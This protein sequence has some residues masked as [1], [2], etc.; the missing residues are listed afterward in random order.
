MEDTMA[1]DDHGYEVIQRAKLLRDGQAIPRLGLGVWQVP[2]GDDCVRSV[3]WA[4]EL[5]YRHID[6]AQGYGNEESVGIA[7][8]QSGIPR[9]DLFVTT[10]FLPTQTDPLAEI[11]MS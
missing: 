8:R 1:I 11:E 4:L 2:N 10:K 7:L 3:T 9:E 5:G 6:T